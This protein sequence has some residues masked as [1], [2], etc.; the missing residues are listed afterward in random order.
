MIDDKALEV[1]VYDNFGRGSDHNL[2]RVLMDACQPVEPKMPS[3]IRT[4]SSAAFKKE[5]V[6]SELNFRK[7]KKT[8]LLTP[9]PVLI[10]LEVK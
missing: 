7:E 5:S 9:I 3:I 8:T 2:A 10:V 4:L 6:S 1:S